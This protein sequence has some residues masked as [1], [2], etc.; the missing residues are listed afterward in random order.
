MSW[1]Y[2][3][4]AIFLL[5]I[6]ALGL[7][8]IQEAGQ[9]V[10]MLQ[11]DLKRETVTVEEKKARTHALIESLG[12]E[13]AVVNA[14]VASSKADEEA[15]AQLQH[16][17]TTFQNECASDLA[18]AEPIIKEAETALNSL[19]KASLGELRSF[20]NPSKEVV[21]VLAA[22][23]I[24]SSTSGSI[25]RDLSWAAGKRFMGNVDT[26]LRMLQNFNKDG[27]PGGVVK[28]VEDDYISQPGFHPD[29]I[30]SKSMAAA[31]LCGWVINICKYFRIYQTVAPKRAALAEA[32]ARLSNANDKLQGIRSQIAELNAKVASLEGDLLKATEEKTEAMAQAERTASKA[33]VAAHLIA[34]LAD[35]RLRWAS[36]IASMK[37]EEKSLI[38][39]V[40]LT[41]AFV[42]YAG[43]FNASMRAH[44][45][46]EVWKPL[47]HEANLG[48]DPASSH[49][50]LIAPAHSKVTMSTPVGIRSY[51][52]KLPR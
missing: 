51:A 24:L 2:V 32:N 50:S 33:G 11:D 45:L 4:A 23:M 9:A 52:V 18:T 8:K 31:G 29:K 28:R 14:A 35:E 1:S 16:E 22:V 7:A 13:R 37:E 39:R 42:I 43:P 49:L 27:L 6:D 3:Y 48:L 44:L 34:G 47:L 26:F 38:G 21:D 36:T 12:R 10:A 19:D 5:L 15:A 20:G 40:L 41:S 25:P 30:K 46:E 17:V